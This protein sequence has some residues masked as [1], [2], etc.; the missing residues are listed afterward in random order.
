MSR[1]TAALAAGTAVFALLLTGCSEDSSTAAPATT[2][3]PAV[4]V[5][6]GKAGRFVVS[7]RNAFP[8]LAAG[9][10]DLA[11]SGVLNQTCSDIKAGKAE[12]DTIAGIV[13]SST[14]GSVS[15]TEQE[16]RAVYDMAKLM[17]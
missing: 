13:K 14:N 17:C 7:Y 16:A 5:D 9:R 11:V 10:D 1:T 6:P 12:A 4:Q 15:A 3:T 2:T 8:K